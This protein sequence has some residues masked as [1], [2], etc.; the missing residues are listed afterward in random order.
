MSFAKSALRRVCRFRLARSASVP[1]DSDPA[2]GLSGR[3]WGV[4]LGR[5]L[6]SRVVEGAIAPNAMQ[7]DREL[8]RRG[9]SGLLEA[10]PLLEAFRPGQ[11]RRWFPNLGD[12]GRCSRVE[13][14]PQVAVTAF[15]D[16][17]RPIHLPGLMASW[18]EAE[19]GADIS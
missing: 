17:P 6:Q 10:L 14:A 19:E 13:Q 4:A 18:R 9:D 2:L 11:Q 16:A 8:A 15:R 3:Y 7:D 5:C 12:Q 1:K